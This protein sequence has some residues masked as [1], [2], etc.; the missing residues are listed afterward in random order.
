M[1]KFSDELVDQVVAATD[2]VD[3]ITSYGLDLKRS[4]GA[5][6]THCPF[7]NEKSPSFHV[8]PGRQ[9][10]KCFGCGEGGGALGFVMKH[11]NLPFQDALRK[12][13]ARVNIEIEQE[14]E[15]DPEADKRKRKM[16]R[17]RE[18]HNKASRFLHEQ[19][20][21]NPAA[22]HARDYLKSRGYD[23]KMAKEWQVGW[24]PDRTELF[25]EWAKKEKFTPKELI[26]AGLA[27]LN[28]EDNRN[29]GIWIRFR[30]RLMFPIQNTYDDVIAFSGRQLRENPNSGKY[31]NSPES[32]IFRKSNVF[33]GLNKARRHI[34]GT[35]GL[36]CEGQIDV[37]A[38]HEAE[39]K[40]A[41]ATLGTAFTPEHA[42]A[43]KRSTDKIVIC[44]DS[45]AAGHKAACRAFEHLADVGME[46][47]VAAM[48]DGEDPD[49]LIKTKGPEA[50][51]ALLDNAAEFFDYLLKHLSK[52]EDLHDPAIKARVVRE[53][54]PFLSKLQ[55]KAAQEASLNF[56]ATRL[57][58]GSESIRDA[59]AHQKFR[60]RFRRPDST[61]EQQIFEP[62]ILDP[63]IRELALLA[64]Q[65]HEVMDYL[66]DQTEQVLT[67]SEGRLGETL[68]RRILSERPDVTDPIAVNLFL[69]RLAKPDRATLLELL[70]E[71]GAEN[72]LEAATE[73]LG[74]LAEQ[75]LIAQMAALGSQLKTPNLPDEEQLEILGQ[76]AELQRMLVEAK[77]T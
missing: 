43:L 34:G 55:D 3:L 72:P 73:T 21:Q 9:S 52:T 33:F 60:S 62:T 45:D 4:G 44:Y 19:L 20:L 46:V 1:A 58:L 31:I 41:F 30:D 5:F 8:N 28:N 13:A 63:G 59:V 40:N 29:S 18:L 48:P 68:L 53:L 49:S 37:I 71:P 16:A 6:K 47:R 50:F 12:L 61:D 2:I 26:S 74:K 76:I 24:M 17:L 42:T 25:I 14:I 10:F 75:S 57:G 15:F 56:V 7:H 67:A 27:K 65:S 38:C 54:A 32:P 64:L 36:L 77:K 39:V 23:S 69:E 66:C 22:Q 35:Y 11:E 51:R 70:E